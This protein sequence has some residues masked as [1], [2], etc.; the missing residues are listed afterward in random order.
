MFQKAEDWF[1]KSWR[2]ERERGERRQRSR[3]R[4]KMG[5]QEVAVGG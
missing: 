3:V 4:G 1:L 5:K 2:G